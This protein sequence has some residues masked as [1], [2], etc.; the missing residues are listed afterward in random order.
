M[1]RLSRRI[2]ASV[3]TTL[4]ALPLVA[5]GAERVAV[6][7]ASNPGARFLQVTREINGA[8]AG[9]SASVSVT[10]Q[11]FVS[12]T[13]APA[14]SPADGT[15]GPIQI[16]F[17]VESLFMDGVADTSRPDATCVV[18]VGSSTCSVTIPS[19]GQKGQAQ[20]RAWIDRDGQ[21]L[22][23]GGIT[24]ADPTEKRVANNTSP[25]TPN[26]N[27]CLASEPSDTCSGAAAGDEGELAEPDNTDV[28]IV[29]FSDAV[30]DTLVCGTVSGR[31]GTAADPVAFGLG[32]DITIRCRAGATNGGARANV[33]I[34][35]ELLK[36]DGHNGGPNDDDQTQND[37]ANTTSDY[38]S[39]AVGGAGGSAFND[40]CVTDASGVCEWTIAGRH[41]GGS[42]PDRAPEAG[43]AR[44]CF[45]IKPT[46]QNVATYQNPMTAVGNDFTP[47]GTDQTKGGACDNVPPTSLTTSTVFVLWQDAVGVDAQAENA[48]VSRPG[49]LSITAKVFNLNGAASVAS[50]K[51]KVFGE[52]FQGSAYDVDGSTPNTP[53]FEFPAIAAGASSTTYTIDTGAS[54]VTGNVVVCVWIASFPTMSGVASAADGATNAPTCTGTA[55]TE[56]RT[57]PT[58]DD[59]VPSPVRDNTDIVVRTVISPVTP[60]SGASSGYWILE[61]SAKVT[62]FD[63]TDFGSGGL[64]GTTTAV[65]IAAKR[66]TSSNPT[67]GGLGYW[68]A[69]AD[70]SVAAKGGATN[71]GNATNVHLQQPIVG[72]A[73]RPQGDGY[74]L[75]GR[76]G[77]IFSYGPGATFHGST[78]N[79]RLNQ[80]VVGIASTPSGNGYWLVASDGGIF[81]FGDAYFAGSMGGQH[82]NQPVVG[83]TAPVTGGYLLV[84][85]DGGMFVY[86]GAQ[87]HGSMG[88]KPLQKPIVGMTSRD[89]GKGYWEVAS[90]GGIFSFDAPFHSSLAGNASFP[91][92]GMAS[93]GSV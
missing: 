27:D 92:V 42:E 29:S 85:S 32:E 53:D 36:A 62:S 17:D 77:G 55:G 46:D 93:F 37:A 20:I 10:A 67:G 90:D 44:L 8:A 51:P 83:M 57:D 26:E 35:G 4:L 79:I 40:G 14:A 66:D 59:G 33:P 56:G 28:G 6:A 7:A 63:A 47:S 49:Q 86:G 84:A 1:A 5:V 73:A 25:A 23:Q 43:I 22:S 54:S 31:R 89:D 80:P 69:G 48:T 3:L 64:T 2:T 21:S 15:S 16:A 91:V 71:F 50:P 19:G 38:Q 13:S 76:D 87:Y 70:G 24:E 41:T 9:A 81:A 39:T 34:D 18:L 72:I 65:G 11:L 12:G 58:I 61:S 52:F 45:W 30:S 60:P 74:W 78:G 75:L 68:I 88:G 82:L